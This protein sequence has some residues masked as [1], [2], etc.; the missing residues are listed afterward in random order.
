M[1]KERR[2]IRERGE[3]RE[4]SG[5]EGEVAEQGVGKREAVGYVK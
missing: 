1:N 4:E 3:N 5:D 2:G